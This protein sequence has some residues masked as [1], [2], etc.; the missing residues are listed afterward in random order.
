MVDGEAV[1][2]VEITLRFA[3][4]AWENEGGA[5]RY[6][7]IAQNGEESDELFDS[8]E[9]ARRDIKDRY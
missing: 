8:I 1:E 5:L 2:N 3:I 6:D 4:R 9:E 7:W